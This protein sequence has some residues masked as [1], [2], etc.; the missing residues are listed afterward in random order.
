MIA[1]AKGYEA[2]I[3]GKTNRI[4]ASVIKTFKGLRGAHSLTHTET[5]LQKPLKDK[6]IAS[7]K[8]S[9]REN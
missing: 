1:K 6:L 5:G 8:L 3:A 4:P 7:G 2:E 9:V